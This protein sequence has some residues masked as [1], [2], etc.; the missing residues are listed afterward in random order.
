ML[1]AKENQVKKLKFNQKLREV[2]Q[3]RNQ[4]DINKK[5]SYYAILDWENNKI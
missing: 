3:L 4:K 2:D 5:V 1:K